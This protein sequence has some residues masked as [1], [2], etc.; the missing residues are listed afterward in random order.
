[1][2]E[3][4]REL[5][6][7]WPHFRGPIHTFGLDECLGLF[8][9][10]GFISDG[11]ERPTNPVVIYR[12]QVSGHANG[13]SYTMDQDEAECYARGYS[14]L[15]ITVVLRATVQPDD[16]LGLF[17]SESEVVVDPSNL[18]GMEIVGWFP[19][20]PPPQFLGPR[21]WEFTR[22]AGASG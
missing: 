22:F 16:V 5:L 18:I 3:L 17:S 15:G 12:G 1:M 10:A 13:I 6:S 9:R 11:A 2:V 8:R 20:F 4:R 21:W 19:Y 14:T 7:Q